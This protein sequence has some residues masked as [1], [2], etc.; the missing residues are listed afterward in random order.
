MEIQIQDLVQS[1]KRDGIEEAKK[2]AETIISAAKAKAEEIIAAS[3]AEAEKNIENANREIESSKAL[4]KQAERDAVL[5]V[6]KELEQLLERILAEKVSKDLSEKSLAALITAAIGNEDPSKYAVEID[7]TKAALKSVLAKQI[8]KGLEI[9][10]VKGMSGMKLSCKDGSGFY[11][12]SDE[13]IAALLRP[14]LG[15]MKI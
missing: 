6:K 5:S 1:I 12:F 3:K 8:E 14:F 4:I 13:E 2:E 9:R 15:D 10:P 11:D 7:E